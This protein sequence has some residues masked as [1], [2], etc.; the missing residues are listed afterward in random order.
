[1][2][3]NRLSRRTLLRGVGTVM[4]LPF[5]EA[6]A[7]LGVLAQ[8]V[9]KRPNR[10]AFIF[11]PNGIHMPAWRPALEGTAFELPSTLQPLSKVRNSLTVLSGLAQT[12]AFALGD[13][14]GD[15]A[16][17]A[18]AFLTGCHPR[19]T[20][21][22]DIKAGI[23]AD[24]LAAMKVGN[25]TRFASLELG[26]ERGGMNGNC[27][28]GYSCAYS[29]NIA[30][31]GEAQPLAHEVD[32]RAVF[33]RLFGNGDADESAESRQLRQSDRISVL[34]FVLDDANRLKSKLGNKDQSKLDEYFTG[35]REIENRVALAEKSNLAS[36]L[37]GADKPSGIPSDFGE[38]MRL[39]FDMMLL[40][41]QADM[42]RIAT[43]MVCND[44]SNRGYKDIGVPEGHHDCSHHGGDKI[45]QAKVQTINHFHI[46][47]LAYL[48]NRMDAI[49]E[50]EGS[51]LD[52]SMVVYGAGISDGDRHNHDDLPIL[53][54]GRGA[55]TIKSGRHIAYPN[56]TP[57]TNL[58]LSMLDRMGVPADHIGDSTGRLQQLF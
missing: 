24:Q 43:F 10:M 57:M 35:V 13:G 12:N 31:R 27:D 37:A 54:A 16:R 28:S 3:S 53:L 21:G 55:G 36:K 47:Q 30:W 7:P 25:R 34:D 4:A 51:M 52:N 58:F 41:F 33:E 39:M 2:S 44:G 8:S 42:T 5:L 20:Y 29:S 46:E 23:S 26:C 9:K 49:H 11:V 38:H 48:L 17:S 32:P 15:H 1:M 6:M 45:K 19:K 40:A 56:P 14:G 18:A 22:A 50:A